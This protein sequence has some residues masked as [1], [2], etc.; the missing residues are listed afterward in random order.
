LDLL[1]QLVCPELCL[2]EKL[3]DTAQAK[4][5]KPQE[6]S[7]SNEVGA[8][9]DELPEAALIPPDIVDLS[10]LPKVLGSGPEL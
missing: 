5:D 3:S 1:G 10:K 4:S 7:P 9:N 2:R 6:L 8:V